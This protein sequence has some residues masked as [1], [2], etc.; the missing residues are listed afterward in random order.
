MLKKR[1]VTLLMTVPGVLIVGFLGYQYWLRHMNV[2][3]PI[4]LA[5]V[6]I[7]ES[8]YWL[9]AENSGRPPQ[10]PTQIRLHDGKEPGFCISV[11]F[12]I[13]PDGRVSDWKVAKI[14]PPTALQKLTESFFTPL[15]DWQFQPTPVNTERRAVISNRV[16]LF[17]A[18]A[19]QLPPCFMP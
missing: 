9:L 1:N 12:K 16:F 2:P 10:K 14:Y 15:K 5:E 19:A 7:A 3:A 4:Q 18:T 8:T 6:G 17:N 13:N 11:D